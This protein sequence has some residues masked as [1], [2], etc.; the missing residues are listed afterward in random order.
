MRMKTLTLLMLLLSGT[1]PSL[2]QKLEGRFDN[3]RKFF[4]PTDQRYSIPKIHLNTIG[5]Y[6]YLGK[7]GIIKPDGTTITEPVYDEV[8][9]YKH[10]A[11]LAVGVTYG[12]RGQYAMF[13][14]YYLIR[15]DVPEEILELNM[16]HEFPV[17]LLDA[18]R[19]VVRKNNQSIILDVKTGKPLFDPVPAQVKILVPYGYMVSGKQLVPDP[20]PNRKVL[21]RMEHDTVCYA[22]YDSNFVRKTDFRF[23]TVEYK[24][25][26]NF[27]HTVCKHG[28]GMLDSAGNELLPPYFDAADYCWGSKEYLTAQFNGV[29]NHETIDGDGFPG[30]NNSDVQI[31]KTDGTVLTLDTFKQFQGY[32]PETKLF[33]VTRGGRH[34]FFVPSPDDLIVPAAPLGY[35]D[36]PKK[37]L[38]RVDGSF[39]LPIDVD[40][41]QQLKKGYYLLEEQ[42]QFTIYHPKEKKKIPITSAYKYIMEKEGFML[43]RVEDGYYLILPN[44]KAFQNTRYD[45]IDIRENLVVLKKG[46]LV[47]LMNEKYEIIIPQ[48]KYIEIEVATRSKKTYIKVGK[49]S[50][51][52]IRF[53]VLNLSGKVI[54]PI[55][56]EDVEIDHDTLFTFFVKKKGKYGLMNAKG[57]LVMPILYDQFHGYNDNYGRIDL[58]YNGSFTSADTSGKMFTSTN[59]YYVS[60]EFWN[61]NALAVNQEG[62]MQLWN[63][64]HESV[65]TEEIQS[66]DM[67]AYTDLFVL[68][69]NQKFGLVNGRGYKVLPLEYDTLYYEYQYRKLIGRKGEKNYLLNLNGMMLENI[70]LDQILYVTDSGQAVFQLGN[71]QGMLRSDGSIMFEPEYDYVSAFDADHFLLKKGSHNVIVNMDKQAVVDSSTSYY[72]HYGSFIVSPKPPCALMYTRDYKKI[73]GFCLR[74]LLQTNCGYLQGQT[75]SGLVIIDTNGKRLNEDYFDMLIEYDCVKK[76]AVVG[77]KGK[78]WAVNEQYKPLGGVQTDRVSYYNQ[79]ERFII[80]KDHRYGLMDIKGNILIPM[81]HLNV[82]MDSDRRQVK[83]TSVDGFTQWYTLDG[84]NVQ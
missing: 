35:V 45:D 60:R 53:G 20:I 70:R 6:S 51:S 74:N 44:G 66:L 48:G 73:D 29:S 19:I 58:V 34:T 27:F 64:L 9:F 84:K 23:R 36:Q 68:K 5:M 80:I 77:V 26:G 2:A 22:F 4:I 1:L 28:K 43:A 40:N 11:K 24:S 7:H 69:S 61:G 18:T 49:K 82:E 72:S 14:K 55:E 57:K 33:I 25:Y 59:G 12:K 54:V 78:L 41:I 42:N 16:P 81:I 3:E 15:I 21:S 79:V 83:V 8:L 31:Y 39:E 10:S 62:K 30:I 71:K 32:N 75:D 17:T 37:N 50:G 63:Q 38:M 47:E 76:V 13:Y 52:E 67:V 65:L 46:S 56:Y